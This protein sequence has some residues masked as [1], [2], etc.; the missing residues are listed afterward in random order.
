MKV[1]IFLGT[2][3]QAGTDMRKAFEGHVEQVRAIRDCGY[4]AVWLPQHYLTHPDEFF[5]LTPMLARLA[6]E[7]GDMAIGPN[8]MVL[9]LHNIIDV[10]EQYA[11]LDII[12]NGKLIL[13]AA[14]GY[15]DEEYDAFGIDRKTRAGRFDEQIDALKLLWETDNATFKGKHVQFENVSIRPKPLQKPRPP[16][17]LG[18]AAD[19]AIR[20]AA[21]KGDN[22]IATSVTTTSALKPQV[23]LFHKTRAEAGLPKLPGVAKCIELFVA[24]TRAEAMSVG[25][26][27]IADKYRAY[28]SW[29]MGKNV[30]GVSGEGLDIAEL[31]KDRFAIGSPDDCIRE[32]ISQRDACGV[33]DLLVRMNFP[34]MP[35]DVSLKTFRLFAKEV[36]PHIR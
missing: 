28:F 34:G 7:S 12:S 10:A 15:R 32:C 35:L 4:D 33:S 36:L 8:I 24:P 19:P 20:R 31:A 16:I 22:W 26:P 14:L 18:A 5:Q 11:T 17:W 1:G 23:D 13:G 21:I 6:A 27:Y 2:Q 29:G 25:G 30:P 3:H 9:P